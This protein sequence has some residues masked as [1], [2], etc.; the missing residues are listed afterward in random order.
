VQVRWL[1]AHIGRLNYEINE[2]DNWQVCLIL[3]V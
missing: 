3:F 2:L 1:E